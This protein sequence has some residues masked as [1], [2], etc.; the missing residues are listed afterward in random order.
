MY[1]IT[2]SSFIPPSLPINK[3]NP[4]FGR[5]SRKVKGQ[6]GDVE[7]S[8]L[9]PPQLSQSHFAVTKQLAVRPYLSVCVYGYEARLLKASKVQ[10]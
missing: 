6:P 10:K 2:F 8:I 4:D 1:Q 3:P 5:V 9:S 7:K